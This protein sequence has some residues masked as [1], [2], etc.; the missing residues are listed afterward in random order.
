MGAKGTS[1]GPGFSQQFGSRISRLL[2]GVLLSV[3]IMLVS[4]VLAD[5][6]GSVLLRA[7]G[8]DPATASSPISGVTVAI[9]VGILL[10]NTVSLP[11]S[12]Q[13]GIRFGV[14]GLLRLGIIFVGV[15]LS[16]LDMLRLGA[17]GIPIVTVSIAGGLILVIWIN[18]SLKLPSRLGTLIAAGTA[19]CG[20]TAIVSVAP[21]IDAEEKEVAY[22]VANI[23]LFGLLGML[24]YPYFAPIVFGTSEQVGLFLG[25]AIHDTAQVI[26]AGLTYQE[27]FGDDIGFQVA[28]VTKLTRNL[29]LAL[30]VPILSF[31]YLK[32]EAKGNE[33][34]KGDK[35]SSIKLSSF[36]PTF[37]LGFIAVAL[38]RTVGDATLVQGAA[39][40]IWQAG[41]WEGIVTRVGDVW[42]SKY[43]L[44]TAMAAVGLGTSFS[45]FK[46]VGFKPFLVGLAGALL[47]GVMG[48]G[49][50]LL[51]GSNVVL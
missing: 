45:V 8:L 43:L 5:W 21:A 47:V 7:Q 14:R 24:M 23:T 34:A 37:V 12:V 6:L 30:V 9:L 27:V 25:M 28:T 29:F 15:K 11:E 19:I 16:L 20:V 46:G 32:K 50:V 48:M 1:T 22:A 35:R 33:G 18:N 3:A 49:M 31:N 41:T 10:R 17:W 39:F 4:L 38:L 13:P 51:L 36:L 2:P 26:G 44:G 42:G 40:R